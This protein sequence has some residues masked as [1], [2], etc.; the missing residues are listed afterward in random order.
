MK[1]DKEIKKDFI[2]LASKNPEK[3]YPLSSLKEKGFKRKKCLKCGRFFWTLSNEEICGDSSCQNGYS[4]IGKKTKNPMNYLEAWENFK[5]FFEKKGYLPLKRYPVV[6][7]WRADSYWVGASVYPF[8]PH[9]VEGNSKPKSNALIIPQPCLRFNDIDNVGLTGAHYV[10]FDMFGQLHFEKPENYKPQLYFDEYFE[11]ITKGMGIKEEDLKI[12]ED[13]WAGAGFGG[14]SFEFFSKGLEIGNQVYMQYFYDGDS[15]KELNV[16]V[17]DMGQ[18]HERI[19]WFTNG[20]PSSYDTTFPTV[21]NYLKKQ[22]SLKIDKKIFAKFV[23]YSSLLNSDEYN[24]KE[25]WEKISSFLDIPA[26][27]LKQQI[28]PLSALYSIA[29][30]TRA[31]L[32]A[33]NDGALPSNVGGGYNL[34]T[35]MRRTFSLAEKYSWNLDFQKIFELHASFLKPLWSNIYENPDEIQEIFE[36]EKRKFFE[37]KKRAKSIIASSLKSSLTTD[38]LI[39]LYDSHGIS[40]ELIKQEAEKQNIKISIPDNF[41]SLLSEKHQSKIIKKEKESLSIP[42]FSTE[43]LFWKDWALVDFTAKVVF[44]SEDKKKI[45]LDKTAFYPFSGGQ[46]CDTGKINNQK[47]VNVIKQGDTIIHFLDKPANFNIG[48]IVKGQVDFQR[49]KILTQHHTGAHLINLC[50]RELLGSH[51]WQAGA[52]KSPDKARLDITHFESLSQ[53]Q[54]LQIEE[55]A[56]NYIKQNLFIKTEILPRE[57][58]EEKYGMRI[59]QGGF[60]PGRNLR[61]VNIGDKEIE[62]CGGTHLHS[63]KEMEKIKI[64]SSSKIQDSVVRITFVCGEKAIQYEQHSSDLLNQICSLLNTEE[65][66]AVSSVENL[67]STWKRVVKKK[68]KPLPLQ[69]KEDSFSSLERLNKICEILKTQKEHL[70]KT[71]KRMKKDLENN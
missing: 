45:V 67:F 5:T 10:A 46:D 1:T 59:Y 13:G 40:P 70:L 12:H 38:K 48:D 53:K 25:S 60:I 50:A 34:R 49:R 42:S 4:F 68:K 22:T 27:N 2:N 7:R 33:L 18:G 44:I 43:P 6:A 64:I 24:L 21:V 31:I 41:Y 61:I 19:P 37:T 35:I 28:L 57:L 62:A 65:N 54:I 30:H 36:H 58:A 3:Y 26:E 52:Y 11:W 32:L 8:Q 51:I 63:T 39:Q 55:K 29:D 17:L 20:N 16:K 56:N 66:K 9:V 71:I 14:T 23:S 69:T 47:V 15:Y